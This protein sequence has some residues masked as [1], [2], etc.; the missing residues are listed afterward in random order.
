M[1]RAA[2]YCRV[3]TEDQAKGFSLDA[4]RER[5]N[6]YCLSRGWDIGGVYVDDGFSGRNTKRP[7]YRRMLQET[8]AWDVLLVLK[9]DRVHRNSRNFLAMIDFLKGEHKEFVSSMESLDT[10]SALGR[11]VMQLLQSIAQLESEQISER[12]FMGMSQKAKSG[13]GVLGGNDPLGYR[14]SEGQYVRVPDEARLVER[15]FGLVA[16]GRSLQDIADYLNKK[17][18]TTKKGT[19][20]NPVKLHRILH[21]PIYTGS[22]RWNGTTAKARHKPIVAEETFRLAQDALKARQPIF[23]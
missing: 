6:A 9:M 14:I 22:I 12:V 19:A 18:S 20:W 21:N 5:L 23:H 11:F 15:I 10:S 17:G 16:A 13:T 3:S 7:E 1:T 2:V 4:Q 8:Y